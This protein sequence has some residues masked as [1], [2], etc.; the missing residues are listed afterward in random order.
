MLLLIT[1]LILHHNYWVWNGNMFPS[2]MRVNP[3][4]DWDTGAQSCRVRRRWHQPCCHV[5]HLLNLFQRYDRGVLL[6][7]LP[8]VE[9]GTGALPFT[10]GFTPYEL[11]LEILVS[12]GLWNAFTQCQ[13]FYR[14]FGCPVFLVVLWTW[15]LLCINFWFDAIQRFELVFIR[16]WVDQSSVVRQELL[17]HWHYFLGLDRVGRLLTQVLDRRLLA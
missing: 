10:R 2:Y 5:L 4:L 16:G 11:L 14:F 3:S 9:K 1:F 7:A 15:Q 17:P 13:I 12:Y 6:T 8:R